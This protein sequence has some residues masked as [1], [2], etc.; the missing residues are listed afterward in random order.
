MGGGVRG[1]AGPGAGGGGS[2]YQPWGLKGWG[3]RLLLAPILH[4]TFANSPV[5]GP[6]PHFT[7]RETEALLVKG[8]PIDLPASGHPLPNFA[9]SSP[10]LLSSSWSPP[11]RH[12]PL[13]HAWVQGLATW[14]SSLSHSPCTS[15]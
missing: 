10:V 12:G 5:D 9:P 14:F 11:G 4:Q 1:G 8:F 6:H 15:G 13:P 2:I 3:A 7:D